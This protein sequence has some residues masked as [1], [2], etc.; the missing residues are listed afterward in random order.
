VLWSENDFY[1][2]DFE[3]EPTRPLAERRTR[4]LPLKD[5]AGM[6][7]SFSYAAYAGLYAFTATRPD[8]FARFEPWGRVWHGWA[9]AAFLRTYIELMGP[10]HVLPTD[11]VVLERLLDAYVLDKALYE[12]QY[13]LNNR[14]DW[15]RIPVAG[16][17]A[18]TGRLQ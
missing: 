12:L 5:V 2:I 11:A 6:V 15:V 9:T 1:I 4:Q 3:G 14:P 17:L 8:D 7:R 13:E 18:I 16:A 10:G